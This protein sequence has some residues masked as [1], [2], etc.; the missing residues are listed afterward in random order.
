MSELARVEFDNARIQ[1]TTQNDARRILQRVL[2]AQQN[3]TRAAI[4]WPFELIQNAHDAG[5][6]DGDDRVEINFM[7]WEDRLVVS[8]TGKPFVAQELAALLSGGSS[9]EFDSEETTGRFGTGFLVTHAVSTQVDVDGVLT[10]KQGSEVFH[11]EL[12]RDGDEES[13]KW[14]IEQANESLENAKPGVEGWISSNPTASFIYHNPS[15]DVVRRGLDRLEQ[16]LPYLY[17]TCSKLGRVV[18]QR[19]GEAKSFEPEC[20]EKSHEGDFD[21]CKTQVNISTTN[22]SSI[23]T[24]VRIGPGDGQSALLTVLEHCGADELQVLVPTEGF[25][26]VFVKFP[27][28]GTDFL[29]F[30]VALEGN[31]AISQ[32]R[33]GIAMN[34][35]DKTAI[36]AA[37]SAF[38]TL[39][40]HAVESGWRDAHKLASLAAPTRTLSGEAESG[41]LQWWNGIVLQTATQTASK[42]LVRTELGLLPALPEQ[43][44]QFVSFPVPAIAA[45]ATECIDYD[46]FHEVVGG[47]TELNL[48]SMEVA[49]SWGEIARQWD[50]AGVPVDRLGLSELTD[51]LKEKGNLVSDLPI[52]GSPY[53]W[54]A[55]LFLLAADMKDQN[56]RDMLNG[57]LPNQ[58]GECRNTDHDYLYVDGGISLEVKDIASALGQDIRSELLHH[59]MEQALMA[60]GY[61]MAND[62]ARNLLDEIDGGEYTESKAIELIL[63]QLAK[64]LP[65]DSQFDDDTRLPTL[66]ASARMILHIADNE[67]LQK[68][69]R[70]PLLT[71]AGRIVYLSGNQQIL[72]PARH[73]PESAQPYAELYADNRLLS[74][75]YC[76]KAELASALEALITVGLVVAAPLFEGRRAELADVNLLREMSQG[77]PET[78][79]AIV[80]DARF[81]QIAFLATDLMQRCGEN[82]ELAKLL[83]GFVLNVA[84]REDQSWR[85]MGSFAGNRTG[86][87]V[88]LTLNRAIWPFE[89][90]VRSWIPVKAPDADAIAPM[91][92]NESNLREILDTSWLKG[93][94]D[95]VDL[96]H[97]VF[98][99]RQ[100][101]LLLDSFGTEIED[102]L[103][104][105]L[106]FPELVKA[107]ANNPDA[108]RFASELKD[109][110]VTLDSV[111][112]FVKDA[113]EDERLL[114]HLADRREQRHRVH[115]NQNLG[116]L[117]ETLVRDN[118]KIA[119][120]SVRRTGVGSDFEIAVET[121]HLANLH[122]T[123]EKLSWLVEVKATRDQ[124]VRMT[125]TQAKTAVNEG[126]RFLLCVVPVESG[127]TNPQA[128]DIWPNMRFVAGLG[129][130]LADLCNNLGDFEDMR[131]DI[132][133]DAATGVQLEISPGPA[134]VRVA[135]SVWENDGFPLDELVVRLLT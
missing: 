89:L 63:D 76:D 22:G 45:D 132:T 14:N 96:L 79:G 16:T 17:A 113:V 133:A 109:T 131:V 87:R 91:P 18:I 49:E 3:P 4:R 104:E 15:S 55:Q 13:I 33:D 60:P 120:F 129:D 48:P 112:D 24:A 20:L 110:D 93:N 126:N 9:K 41:E 35:A 134:R 107:A 54:L 43:E 19:F 90:K 102:D 71:A 66:T 108:V 12:V 123:K 6:R 85:E 117:I 69:R 124:R 119:G 8:H 84:A 82:A 94:R 121:G 100:L 2:A 51:R 46:T 23:V 31:F 58:H 135:S 21:V 99:F 25:A 75:S 118:L 73:W 67:D 101:T 26:R 28:A 1:Q 27:V 86:E 115:E 44:R 72:A 7:L 81:G 103:V 111:R 52:Q 38:P 29:P 83:L 105:L 11:I 59:A 114:E 5:P 128:A 65:N 106:Q 62:L 127:D 130:R 70:C 56:V 122:I 64:V 40:Q 53:S 10:T 61:E 125:D 80:R 42:P 74:D 34:D 37:L 98:G 50:Q 92:A 47:V 57:L 88:S 78:V 39:I 68:L 97:Q 30:N 32:E 95:A 116:A 77:E 36:D